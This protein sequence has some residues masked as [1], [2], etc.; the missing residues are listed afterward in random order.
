MVVLAL[1]HFLGA[2]TPLRGG[3][4]IILIVG[5]LAT[6][7]ATLG[8]EVM[9]PENKQKE[10]AMK[11]KGARIL[12]VLAHRTRLRILQVS[13]FKG[14]VFLRSFRASMRIASRNLYSGSKVAPRGGSSRSGR[15]SGRFQDACRS[16]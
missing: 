3:S 11:R 15:C 1:I 2:L 5:V 10:Y 4:D 16:Y 13:I 14:M 9:R 7:L 12:L 6:L 8:R